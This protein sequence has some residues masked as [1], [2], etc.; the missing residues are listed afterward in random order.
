MCILLVVVDNSQQAKN[1]MEGQ[2]TT[3]F[4]PL[5]GAFSNFLAFV[6]CV[7]LFLGLC[8]V[9]FPISWPFSGP[10]SYFLAFV[11]CMKVSKESSRAYMKFVW[12]TG[13][14]VPAHGHF[15]FRNKIYLF[16]SFTNHRWFVLQV[17]NTCDFG[18][19]ALVSVGEDVH[20][21][22]MVPRPAE[23]GSQF[24]SQCIIKFIAMGPK[25]VPVG[26]KMVPVNAKMV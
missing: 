15:S 2:I 17:Y 5:S 12:W 13:D 3:I 21:L 11:W 10:F 1:I 19:V 20:I 26:P 6:W 7:S 23:A 9:H 14:W 25:R 22:V 4:W 24:V 16:I 8:L 18:G